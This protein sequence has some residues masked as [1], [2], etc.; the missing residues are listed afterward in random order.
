MIVR[1]SVSSKT[2]SFAGGGSPVHSTVVE[3]YGFGGFSMYRI[4]VLVKIVRW[5]APLFCFERF[6]EERFDSHHIIDV[7]DQ[8][9]Y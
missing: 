9:F 5:H 7:L 4:Y 3:I 1:V 2:S 6:H 8:A